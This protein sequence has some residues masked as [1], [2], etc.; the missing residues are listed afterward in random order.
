MTDKEQE[1]MILMAKAL[2]TAYRLLV[3]W[4]II[5]GKATEPMNEIREAIAQY[6]DV[7]P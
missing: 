1:V 2:K 5:G 3:K 6:E 7:I 4:E